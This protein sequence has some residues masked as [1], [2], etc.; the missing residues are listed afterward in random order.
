MIP[1][2]DGQRAWGPCGTS[3]PGAP[4]RRVDAPPDPRYLYPPEEAAR[5][6]GISRTRV[7]GL[8][9][10]G[11]LTRIKNG[12]RTLVSDFEVQELVKRLLSEPWL[13]S[14]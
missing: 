9:N 13:L 2:A 8:L 3:G 7:Y 14:A 1:R 4:S 6:L 10:C 11:L 5:R 12:K